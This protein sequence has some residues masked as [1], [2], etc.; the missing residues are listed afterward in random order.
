MKSDP[1]GNYE[2]AAINE[3]PSTAFTASAVSL[4]DAEEDNDDHILFMEE[5]KIKKTKLGGIFRRVKRVLER[6]TNIKPGGNNIR[7]AN[8][9]FAIQ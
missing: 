2:I 7:V 3:Q 4:K 1:R 6:K 5:D 9:E 8:L